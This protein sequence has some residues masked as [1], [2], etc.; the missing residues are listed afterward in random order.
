MVSNLS[1]QSRGLWFLL[2]GPIAVIIFYLRHGPI[3]RGGWCVS[4]NSPCISRPPLVIFQGCT[5]SA[6][7]MLCNHVPV[8]VQG[9]PHA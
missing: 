1:M 3:H 8:H 9:G 2:N 6:C 7:T 5:T 4:A